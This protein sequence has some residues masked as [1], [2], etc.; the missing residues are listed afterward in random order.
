M[1]KIEHGLSWW[2]VAWSLVVRIWGRVPQTGRR[3]ALLLW[4]CERA[5]KGVEKLLYRAFFQKSS[6]ILLKIQCTLGKLYKMSRLYYLA[7]RIPDKE[8]FL[9]RGSPKTSR[10]EGSLDMLVSKCTHR[11]RYR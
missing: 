10:V 1:G 2:I 8:A 3:V 5:K 7:R 4:A 11:C 6:H 9:G